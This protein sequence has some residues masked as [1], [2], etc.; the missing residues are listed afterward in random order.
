MNKYHID[1]TEPA[2][3]DLREI[4]H[5]ILRELL[6]PA[7]ANKL[8]G[9][10]GDAILTLEELPLRNPLITDEKMSKRGIRKLLIDN[11]IVFYMVSEQQR[12]VTIIRILYG[13]RDWLNLI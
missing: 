2:E 8:V 9:K 3:N 7:I 4:G 1:I 13:R 6:E 5:Y 10:I 11:Y 12:T